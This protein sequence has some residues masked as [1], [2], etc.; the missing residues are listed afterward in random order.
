[1]FFAHECNM[2]WRCYA[3]KSRRRGRKSPHQNWKIGRGIPS[4]RFGEGI[5]NAPTQK[6]ESIC[7]SCGCITGVIRKWR[8][9]RRYVVHEFVQAVFVKLVPLHRHKMDINVLTKSLPSP[10][11]ISLHCVMIGQAPFERSVFY[12]KLILWILWMRG[13]FHSPWQTLGIPFAFT[14]IGY[15]HQS[16][17]SLSLGDHAKEL[18][19]QQL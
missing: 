10:A 13:S 3:S 5:G 16:P 18:V 8:G 14:P 19:A 9:E 11:F 2:D 1:M 7:T 6:I 12:E 17:P 4:P 15:L